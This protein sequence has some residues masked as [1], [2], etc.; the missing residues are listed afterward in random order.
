MAS[1]SPIS[2]KSAA[3]A[4]NTALEQLE[5]AIAIAAVERA[6]AAGLRETIQAQLTAEW[7]AR[8]SDLE[9]ELEEAQTEVQLLRAENQRLANQFQKLQQEHLALQSSAS[10]TLNQLNAS[11][12]QLDF[13]LEASA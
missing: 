10:A 7:E 2:L 1:A 9:N 13:L 4:A 6:N 8:S 5:A 11:V 3:E 12:T